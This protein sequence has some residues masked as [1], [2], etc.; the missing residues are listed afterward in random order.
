MLRPYMLTLGIALRLID[1]MNVDGK[2][3][4]IG[5]GGS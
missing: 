2:Y 3:N 5:I 1:I 4:V